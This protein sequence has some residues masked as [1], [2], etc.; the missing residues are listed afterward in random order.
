MCAKTNFVFGAIAFA[1]EKLAGVEVHLS[2]LLEQEVQR[3]VTDPAEDRHALQQLDRQRLHGA[4]VCA[5]VA[6]C[7]TLAGLESPDRVARPRAR[8]AATLALA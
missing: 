6:R 1:T 5:I 7:A 2:D 8:S 4:A 3:L